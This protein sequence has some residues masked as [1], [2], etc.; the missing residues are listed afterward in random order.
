MSSNGEGLSAPHALI[1]ERAPP[2]SNEL[3]SDRPTDHHIIDAWAAVAGVV[4]AMAQM[5][6]EIDSLWRD[7]VSGETHASP[8]RL[9]EA[10]HTLRRAVRVLERDHQI[11]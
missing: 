5:Q 3:A 1:G 10:S 9:V 2:A 4:A 6:V 7:A 8:E 11:G